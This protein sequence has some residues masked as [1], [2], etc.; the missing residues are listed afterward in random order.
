MTYRNLLHRLAKDLDETELDQHV[1]VYS[2][3]TKAFMPIEA[4]GTI[5][6]SILPSS[7]NGILEHGQVILEA[8]SL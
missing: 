7:E 8:G 1:L 2:R 3:V 5:T 4:I 6:E